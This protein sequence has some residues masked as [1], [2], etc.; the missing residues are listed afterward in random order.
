[1]GARVDQACCVREGATEGQVLARANPLHVAHDELQLAVAERR[2]KVGL[3][4]IVHAPRR[5]PPHRLFVASDG[6]SVDPD[7]SGVSVD[8]GAKVGAT[9]AAGTA[10]DRTRGVGAPQWLAQ[11]ALISPERLH[12]LSLGLPAHPHPKRRRLRKQAARPLGGEK[13]WCRKPLHRRQAARRL[14]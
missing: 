8:R 10:D 11:V 12:T 14:W 9:Q 5:A 2:H 1:M 4:R 3:L 13:G 6:R 7:H